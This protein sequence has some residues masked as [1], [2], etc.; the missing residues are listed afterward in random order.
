MSENDDRDPESQTEDASEKKLQDLREKGQVGKSAELTAAVSLTVGAMVLVHRL[1]TAS[2]SLRATATSCF[3]LR[4]Y[5]HPLMSLGLASESFTLVAVPV[6]LASL[7][8]AMVTG[9]AQTR[10]W[11]SMAQLGR[12]WEQLSPVSGFA[13][14]VPGKDTAIE[15]GKMIS[16]VLLLGVVVATVIHTA[17]PRLGLLSRLPI[18]A[19]VAEVQ[20]VAGTLVTRALVAL[21]GLAALDYWLAYRRFAKEAR[22]SKQEMKDEHKEQEG[23]P[24]MKGKRKARAMKIARQRAISDVKKATVL[25]VNPTHIAIALRY[26]RSKETAPVVLAKGVDE[27]ALRMREEA[28]LHRVPIVE[29]RPLARAMHATAKV[30]R[31]IPV[32][33][34][35]AVARVI[36]HVMRIQGAIAPRAGETNGQVMR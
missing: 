15:I 1:G 10:G 22:M 21:L 28:R 30:G 4:G 5:A 26:D 23:D 3:S 25:V 20:D 18:L 19:A 29:N 9:L 11:F 31:T 24:K 36:A 6:A 27:L 33:L 34:Y 35:E 7:T 16:K 8:A 32:E 12:N 17:L 14:I 13:R 2:G